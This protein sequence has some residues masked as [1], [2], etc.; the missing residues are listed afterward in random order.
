MTQNA[1]G[2]V[3]PSFQVDLKRQRRRRGLHIVGIVAI[4]LIALGAIV[5]AIEEAVACQKG[6]CVW[7]HGQ[8]L[9][10]V[11]GTLTAALAS[12]RQGRTAKT[13]SL[14]HEGKKKA[15]NDDH[16]NDFKHFKKV[17]VWW[18][19]FFVGALAAVVAEFIDWSGVAGQ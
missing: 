18:Y 15:E 4:A 13:K 14:Y 10:A 16:D 12:F 8:H 3:A 6:E 5:G 19:T 11:L 17:S 7:G 1:P 9:L 2:S